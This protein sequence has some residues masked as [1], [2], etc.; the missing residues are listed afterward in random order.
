M[1]S[2]TPGRGGE[3]GSKKGKFLRTSFMDGPLVK[4]QVSLHSKQ[5]YSR[6]RD[7]K[8]REGAPCGARCIPRVQLHSVSVSPKTRCN[9]I[10]H[11]ALL[12][13]VRP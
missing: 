13:V 7:L 8:S 5:K 6:L 2:D 9:A 1:I 11:Y 4:A 12:S 10:T 3:G